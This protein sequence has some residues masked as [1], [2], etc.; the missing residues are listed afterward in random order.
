MGKILIAHHVIE[1]DEWRYVGKT[2]QFLERDRRRSQNGSSL[3][4]TPDSSLQQVQE[5]VV[6]Y[7]VPVYD[8]TG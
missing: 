6:F 5:F 8:F 3:Q 2:H 1:N 4:R 7:H